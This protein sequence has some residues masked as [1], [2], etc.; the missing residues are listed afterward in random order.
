MNERFIEFVVNIHCGTFYTFY[1]LFY[2]IWNPLLYN[3]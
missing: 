3:V 2:F 1:V